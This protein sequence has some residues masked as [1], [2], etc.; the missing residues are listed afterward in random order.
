MMMAKHRVELRGLCKD[1]SMLTDVK[2]DGSVVQITVS[3]GFS[4]FD[5]PYSFGE[6]VD[7]MLSC[8]PPF[9]RIILMVCDSIEWRSLKSYNPLWSDD[10]ARS[11]AIEKGDEWIRNN[12]CAIAKLQNSQSLFTLQRWSSFESEHGE[13]YQAAVK[14]MKGIY[15]AGATCDDIIGAVA[16]HKSINSKASEFSTNVLKHYDSNGIPSDARLN[17]EQIICLSIDYLIEECGIILRFWAEESNL[18]ANYEVYPHR[19]NEF[20]KVLVEYYIH[21]LQPHV[22]KAIYASFRKK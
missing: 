18:K 13:R 2:N 14:E 1:R 11:I 5:D 15:D 10:E 19:R 9:T 6:C 7:K 3:V 4:R 21:P 16:M 17:A 22:L 8:N 20:L 12:Q